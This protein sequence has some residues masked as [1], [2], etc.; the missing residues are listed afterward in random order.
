[1]EKVEKIQL[2]ICP[3]GTQVML[4]LIGRILNLKRIGLSVLLSAC[5]TALI[6]V[7]AG[8]NEAAVPLAIF[9]ALVLLLFLALLGYAVLMRPRLRRQ[10][11]AQAGKGGR[12]VFRGTDFTV[13]MDGEPARRMPYKAIRGQYWA[14]DYY[15]L[16]IDADS[17]KTL[18][19]F[20]IDEDSFDLIY[21][22]AGALTQHKI[23]FIQVKKGTKTKKGAVE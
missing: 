5:L 21:M 8:S 2:K 16:Y 20:A 15:I 4:A 19:C 9:S 1:M 12:A 22:L 7:G 6:L 10:V 14:G 23:K 18:L 17:Y 3:D 11:A 13:E